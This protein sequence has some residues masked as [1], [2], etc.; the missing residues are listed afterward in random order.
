MTLQAFSKLSVWAM[1][2]LNDR[3]KKTGERKP[4]V[5]MVHP[6]TI[7]RLLF[8]LIVSSYYRV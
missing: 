8:Y 6:T 3:K 5:T 2:T 4:T 7:F 1:G